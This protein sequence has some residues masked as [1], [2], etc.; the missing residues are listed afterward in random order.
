MLQMKDFGSWEH[1]KRLQGEADP[2]L[3][4]AMR[5]DLYEGT[6]YVTQK[7]DQDPYGVI[8]E[9]PEDFQEHLINMAFV[10]DKQQYTKLYCMTR[11]D[12]DPSTDSFKPLNPKLTELGDAAVIVYRPAEFF[13]RIVDYYHNRYSNLYELDADVVKYRSLFA[14]TR[15]WDIF[16]KEEDYSWQN[17]VRIAAKLRDEIGVQEPDQVENDPFVMI[18]DI[19]DIAVEVPISDLIE[20]RIPSAIKNETVLNDLRIYRGIPFGL[21]VSEVT[22]NGYFYTVYPSR[23]WIDH[24]RSVFSEDSWDPLTDM[25]KI[26]NGGKAFPA[27]VFVHKTERERVL[28]RWNSIIFEREGDKPV[29]VGF[30]ETVVKKCLEKIPAPLVA[31]RVY[32]IFNL[33]DVNGKYAKYDNTGI[34]RQTTE[35][36]LRMNYRLEQS[37]GSET[38]IFG[39]TNMV[40]KW[41]FTSVLDDTPSI[42]NA[43]RTLDQILA[44]YRDM[45]EMIQKQVDSLQGDD[46]YERFSHLR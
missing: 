40:K 18:G 9:L 2:T 31:I 21:S 23:G 10:D 44:R 37:F 39:A 12:L 5:S 38:N 13:R 25:Q 43:G 22:I 20:G 32:E 1:F 8:K 35:N 26:V 6:A 28:F 16:T 41:R 45:Q 42:T 36:G 19:S 33:G 11:L 34:N 29:D 17:E 46:P 14:E 27:L 7:G 30:V 24:L 3:S 4:K 15:P